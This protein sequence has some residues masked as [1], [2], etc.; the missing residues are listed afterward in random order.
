M[1]EVAEPRRVLF[2]FAW[3]VV[4]GEETEVR[5]LARN[6][7]PRRY[8]IEVIACLRKPNMPELSHSQLQALG[9]PIDCTPY[10]LSFDETVEYLSPKNGALRPHCRVP[11]SA[12]C[13]SGSG[14]DDGAASA[15]RT[16]RAGMRSA[17][18]TQA[19]YFP[20]RRSMQNNSG[21]RGIYNAGTPGSRSRNSLHG[22]FNG[23]QK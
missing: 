22:G 9:I 13:V 5:L 10:E 2:I 11:G 23:I 15:D 8:S 17:G 21:C 3:L 6:L 19:F 20:V 4:G 14:A 18:R 1:R 16:R 12:R 7:D